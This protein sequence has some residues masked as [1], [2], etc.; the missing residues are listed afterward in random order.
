MIRGENYKVYY[1]LYTVAIA[2]IVLFRCPSLLA[3]SYQKVY[4]SPSDVNKSIGSELVVSVMYDV[5]DDNN[6]LAGVGVRFHYDSSK[7]EYLGHSNE[8]AFGLMSSPLE[9]LEDPMKTDSDPETDRMIVTGWASIQQSSWPGQ[10][11]PVKLIDYTF[12]VKSGIDSSDTSLNL[13]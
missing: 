11:L 3:A 1:V 12:K 7:L 2:F 5:S 4:L 10:D 9:K 8:F 6:K 13:G